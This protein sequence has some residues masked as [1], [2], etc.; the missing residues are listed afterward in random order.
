MAGMLTAAKL[1]FF[2]ERLSVANCGM[3][4]ATYWFFWLCSL[5]L[6]LVGWKLKDRCNNRGSGGDFRLLPLFCS[7]V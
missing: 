4:D 7:L 5:L 1:I 6:L 2:N 3:K